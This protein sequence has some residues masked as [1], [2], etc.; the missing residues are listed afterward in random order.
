MCICIALSFDNLH[1]V[2]DCYHFQA[3]GKG[4]MNETE[5]TTVQKPN[6][7]VARKGFKH[8]R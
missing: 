7:V 6:R 1:K 2:I 5:I 8:I 4:N 3:Y